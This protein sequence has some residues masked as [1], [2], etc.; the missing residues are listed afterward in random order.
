[1]LINNNINIHADINMNKNVNMHIHNNNNMMF[2]NE[3]NINIIIMNLPGYVRSMHVVCADEL[4][5]SQNARGASVRRKSTEPC[6]R[7]ASVRKNS[8]YNGGLIFVQGE[9][10]NTLPLEAPVYAESP[11]TAQA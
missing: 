9:G 5:I 11:H 8:T 1:M 10:Q 3:S 6:A 2:I 4:V 7:G